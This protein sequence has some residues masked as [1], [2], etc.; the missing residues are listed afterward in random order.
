MRRLAGNIWD[1]YLPL[2]TV[3]GENT[4]PPSPVAGW[5]LGKTPTVCMGAHQRAFAE[6][7]WGEVEW[8]LSWALG[9]LLALVSALPLH[10]HFLGL[11]R[12][13]QWKLVC[14]GF[15]FCVCI[16]LPGSCWAVSSHPCKAL[17]PF[18]VRFVQQ[19]RE[20]R[21]P[22][23]SLNRGVCIWGC[24]AAC[25][26]P[27]LSSV[28]PHGLKKSLGL[29][30]ELNPILGTLCCETEGPLVSAS[31]LTL[32][33]HSWLWVLLVQCCPVFRCTRLPQV[34]C[35]VALDIRD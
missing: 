20:P 10:F 25:W 19:R 35:Q 21:E 34:K 9:G 8:V 5:L 15:S 7:A 28:K 14:Q 24:W 18:R 32:P 13:V 6:A 30:E 1:F 2:G 22:A 27:L 29:L 11:K 26:A 17:E 31:H 3:R 16:P 4:S 33:W 23:S 12:G